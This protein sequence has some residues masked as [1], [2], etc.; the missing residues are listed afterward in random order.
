MTFWE[1]SLTVTT[2]GYR[3]VASGPD[4]DPHKVFDHLDVVYFYPFTE[5]IEVAGY[6]GTPCP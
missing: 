3:G 1:F 2:I 5:S 6:Q 4:I